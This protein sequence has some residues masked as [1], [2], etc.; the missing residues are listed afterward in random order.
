MH[1]QAVYELPTGHMI[2]WM[3]SLQQIP[4]VSIPAA[5]KYLQV[6]S[7]VVEVTFDG[8]Q[9]LRL[10]SI[11]PPPDGQIGFLELTVIIQVKIMHLQQMMNP[12][13]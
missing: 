3:K 1:L 11:I 6:I 9:S 12:A 4:F 5:V 10:N 7:R 8:V 2:T 13:C